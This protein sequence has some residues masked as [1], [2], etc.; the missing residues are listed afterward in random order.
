MKNRKSEIGFTLI[1][2]MVVVIIVGLLAAIAVPS[3][4]SYVRRA[5]TTEA[6]SIC[7]AIWTAVEIYSI[8]GVPVDANGNAQID[9]V[10]N[11]GLGATVYYTYAVST[12]DTTITA[13]G[14]PGTRAEGLT[15]TMHPN[16]TRPE[17]KFVI[18]GL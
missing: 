1:E 9:T 17:G 18:T 6:T 13:S 15:V 3:Y 8:E 7:G 16:A 14:K 10:Y 12:A 11:V 4:T 5:T 2:M